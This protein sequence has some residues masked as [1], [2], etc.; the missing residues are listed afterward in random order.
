MFERRDILKIG[1]AVAGTGIAASLAGAQDTT[2][3]TGTEGTTGTETTGTET[4]TGE[5]GQAPLGDLYA[6]A[7]MTG[8]A[9]EPEGVETEASGA[10]V[11]TQEEG[12]EVGY[13]LFVADIENVIMAHIHLGGSGESGEVVQW[14]YPSTD[15][16][17]PDLIEGQFSGLLAQGIITGENLVG[18][19]EGESLDRL[20]Q[21][22]Q[23]GNTYVNVHTEQNPQGEIRGQIA[24]VQGGGAGTT[25]TETEA[26]T[27]TEVSTATETEVGTEGGTETGTEVATET[28]SG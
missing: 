27:E 8:M 12:G 28:P 21:E 4:T 19:L 6:A 25:A 5:T 13:Q 22:M 7:R 9:Q 11:F 23:A 1:A 10:G 14:L 17:E 16:T 24:V 15:A 18:P 2:T 3:G 26:G 20:I